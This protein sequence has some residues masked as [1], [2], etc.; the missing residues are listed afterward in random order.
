MNYYVPVTLLENSEKNKVEIIIERLKSMPNEKTNL[1]SYLNAST[2]LT[3][4][5]L[6]EEEIKLSFAPLLYEGLA[7]NEILEEV[8]YS[9]SLSMKDSLNIQN[10]IFLE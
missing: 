4:Y 6:L 2:E 7:S 5:E 10:V 8:K 1:M 3:N 9:I